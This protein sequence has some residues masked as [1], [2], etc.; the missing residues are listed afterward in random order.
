[1][2]LKFYDLKTAG[3]DVSLGYSFC[4]EGESYLAAIQ[5][6]YFS[7][8]KNRENILQ[9]EQSEDLEAYTREVHALKSN[10]KMIGA[11]RMFA[12]CEQLE[13]CG[14]KKDVQT[15]HEMTP[16]L[17]DEYTNVI[18]LL[19]PYGKFPQVHLAN[20]IGA[21]EAKELGRQAIDAI[22]DFDD[23]LALVLIEKLK[24]YPFRYRQKGMLS[25]ACD[26]IAVLEYD[27]A[28]DLVKQAVSQI[29]D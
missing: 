9:H 2:E 18:S 8:E 24:G 15:I 7:Y 20:E 13:H 16:T 6:Y 5:R 21:D 11:I 14:R 10:S 1:M 27:E 25:R 12:I 28:L 29:E 19:E 26:S 23:E 22:V 17:I 4:G 3:I